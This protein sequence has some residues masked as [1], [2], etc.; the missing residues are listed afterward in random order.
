MR[1]IFEIL[2]RDLKS[3]LRD[4]MI[5]YILVVPFL[6]AVILNAVTGSVSQSGLTL[7][8]PESFRQEEVDYLKSYAKVTVL[9]SQ[10]AVLDRVRDL[11]D[12]YGILKK[13]EEYEVLLQGNEKIP[14]ADTV[15]LLLD[16]LKNQDLEVPMEVSVT[17]VG[18]KLSP[19]K[20]FGGGL[21]AV[22]ISVFGGMIIMINLVEEKQENTLLA[23]N[24]SPVTRPQYLTGKAL[25]GFLIPLVHVMGILFIL[26]YGD[27]NYLMA[28]AVTVSIALISVIIGF[29]IGVN[30]DNILAAISGMKMIFLPILGSVFGAIYLREPLQVLLY[31]SP[32]YWAFRSMNAIILKEAVWGDIALS[33][34]MILGIAVVL[35]LMMRKKIRRGLR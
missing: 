23:M 22:F 7:L 15:S 24:V 34:L 19:L 8:V 20:Q 17:D 29:A 31:W 6:I 2:K 14:L 28:A 1:K 16:G 3:G 18:W 11:D 32:F 9:P 27:I 13:G 30:S 4:Y 21:L 12:V 35:L 5:L 26:N 33:T 25:L 10:E